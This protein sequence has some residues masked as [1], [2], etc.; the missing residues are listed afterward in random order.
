MLREFRERGWIGT[1]ELTE[2][3][4]T[5]SSSLPPRLSEDEVLALLRHADLESSYAMSE[6]EHAQPIVRSMGL[7]T[8][9]SILSQSY[10][11]GTGNGAPPTHG[12]VD[13]RK[14]AVMAAR[15]RTEFP[16]RG[17]LSAF[18]FVL[19]TTKGYSN[20]DHII[21]TNPDGTVDKL[22]EYK[23]RLRRRARQQHVEERG[24]DRWDQ[25]AMP[26][27]RRRRIKRDIDAPLAPPEPPISSYVIFVSQMTTKLRNDNPDRH[28]NQAVA[29]KRIAALWNK[30]SEGD[31]RHYDDLLRD[32]RAEYESRILEYRATGKWSP[33][34]QCGRLAK[35]LD[36]ARRREARAAA[37][38]GKL[39]CLGPWVRLDPDKKN[40]LERE[41]DTYK[42]VVF[43]L[44]P[45][46]SVEDHERR[47]KESYLKRRKKIK[48]TKL[49]GS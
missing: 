5:M 39:D 44:R 6:L 10:G 33:Y 47:A 36:E 43:P 8:D 11:G 26:G 32:S 1:T 35:N 49:V 40:E 7:S 46:W 22:E 25:P 48:E 13:V 16:M 21:K 41:L 27:K 37:A 15:S 17:S 20:T 12:V 29:S 34:T 45:Q 24:S 31:K 19:S 14:E 42:T 23:R 30:L 18:P 9:A 38:N 2:R 28:Y 3:R 4:L